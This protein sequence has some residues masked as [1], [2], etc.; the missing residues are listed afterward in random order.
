MEHDPWLRKPIIIIGTPRSGTTLLGQVLRAHP[1]LAYLEEPRIIWRYGNDRRSDRLSPSDARPEVCRYIRDR[2]AEVVQRSGCQRLLEKTPS[3]SLRMGF[4]ERVL[5]GCRFVHIIRHGCDSALSIRD[6]WQQHATG[7]KAGKAA[8][9]L[10]EIRWRQLPYYAKEI[11]R[12]GLGRRFPRLVRPPVWG[13]R[14]PGLDGL[15]R[16]LELLEVCA[17][18]WRTC[19]E[20]ACHYGRT[21]P[22]DRYMECRLEDMGEDLLR[23]VLEFAELEAVDPVWSAFHERFDA[24]LTRPRRDDAD[25]ADVDAILRWIEPTLM[26]LGYTSRNSDRAAE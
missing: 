26:W 12:R 22:S 11:V 9:R 1:S 5:P 14:I 24:R 6:F 4:V 17:L 18:Q 23:E 2:F 21:L 15:V 13:P 10:R 20:S 25:P 7:I 19:V 3:N 8:Q 16:E